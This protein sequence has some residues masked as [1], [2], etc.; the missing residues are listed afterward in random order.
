M[1]IG[2]PA[3]AEELISLWETAA[4]E[5][6][7]LPLV[8]ALDNSGPGR[9]QQ[10]RAWLRAN[11]VVA[12]FNVPHV[13]QHNAFVERTMGELECAVDGRRARE[14]ARP[15]A[16]LCSCG[17]APAQLRSRTAGHATLV[18]ATCA[19]TR[20]ERVPCLLAEWASAAWDLSANTPRPKLA[21]LTADELDRI[22][23]HAEDHVRRARFYH[24]ACAAL[25]RAAAGHPPGRAR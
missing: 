14:A 19:P 8:I 11:A 22:A 12:L 2:P 25:A 3:T 18:C 23:P 6:G 21:G 7:T 13:P 10:V 17:R 5:R 1:A 15:N 4:R 9:S 20:W 24:D 16:I